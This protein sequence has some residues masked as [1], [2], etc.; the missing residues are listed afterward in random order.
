MAHYGLPFRV[1]LPTMVLAS[2][3]CRA[4]CQSAG[5]KGRKALSKS[6]LYFRGA[7]EMDTL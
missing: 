1:K 3:H 7:A 4:V 2:F 5:T 6:R